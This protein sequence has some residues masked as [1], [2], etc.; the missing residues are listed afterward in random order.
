MQQ[1]E[2]KEEPLDL[3][4]SNEV[5]GVN[6][7]QVNN[8]LHVSNGGEVAVQ[9][10]SEEEGVDAIKKWLEENSCPLKSPNVLP[11]SNSGDLEVLE[12]SIEIF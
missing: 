5:E 10:L 9:E 4:D 11:G 3:D 6:E 8:T 12:F 2:E 7:Q 1:A